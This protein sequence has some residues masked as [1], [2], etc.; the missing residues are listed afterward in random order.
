MGSIEPPPLEVL[1]QELRSRAWRSTTF[2]AT[3]V[4]LTE[5]AYAFLDYRVHGTLQLPLLRV[6]HV[7]WSL[8]VLGVLLARRQMLSPRSI[9][10]LFATTVGL[11]LPLFAVAEYAMA[12]SGRAWEPMTGH[13][14][15]MLAISV[16]APTRL[17]L[18]G[19]LIAA[20]ALEA[21]VLWY[22]LG[23]ARLLGGFLW[24]PWLTLVYGGVALGLLG[25]RVRNHT[26]ELKLRQARAEAEALVRLARLLLALRD[27]ANTPLQTLE[28]ALTLLRRGGPDNAALLASMERAVHRLRAL[29][30]RMAGADELLVWRE[31]EESFDAETVLKQLEVELVRELER[32]RG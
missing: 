31:G 4:A 24:E 16:L 25:W 11:F 9:D 15:V 17:W 12:V 2:G 32:R 26:V 1:E 20:F 7:L 3:M 22:A 28:L 19:G 8:A 6:L 14:L 13:R 29:T 18:G 27:A 30:Q 23:M 10:A 21:V 5:L